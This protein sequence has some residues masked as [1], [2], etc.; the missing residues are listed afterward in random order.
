MALIALLF[1]SSVAIL[2]N[3]TGAE[4]LEFVSKGFEDCDKWAISDG[5]C[6]KNP[7]FMWSQ[8]HSSCLQHAVNEKDECQEWAEEGECTNNPNYIQ[9]HCPESCGFALGWSP[10]MRREAGIRDD[11][12]YDEKMIDVFEPC[13]APG[14]LFSA[15]EMVRQR[16]T[17]YLG[18][19]YGFVKGLSST[20]P[21]EYLGVM[22]LTEAFLYSLRVYDVILAT[23][24]E[25]PDGDNIRQN[26]KRRIDEI[27]FVVAAGYSSDKLSKSLRG[28]LPL[29]NESSEET[30]AIMSK[31]YGVSREEAIESAVDKCSADYG[32]TVAAIAEVLNAESSPSDEGLTKMF[33]PYGRL[34]TGIMMP[35]MGL[36]TWQMEGDECAN[37]VEA[38]LEIGYRHIDT[39]EAYRNEGESDLKNRNEVRVI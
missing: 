13:Y 2:V 21:S 7:N 27:M 10:W 6:I 39:A 29:L 33:N 17:T 26:I 18:G 23:Y 16:L 25:N 32:P 5:E 12:K 1:I 34:H 14:D 15:A 36:G 20:A 30:K 38:A 8:C 4:F 35:L 28:W 9:L 19:G 37:A 31:V 11:I 24:T 22:G 3:R